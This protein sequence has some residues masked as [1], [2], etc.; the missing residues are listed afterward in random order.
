[1]VPDQPRDAV[2]RTRTAVLELIVSGVCATGPL[3][4]HTHLR[5]QTP[6]SIQSDHPLASWD[7]IELLGGVFFEGDP[8]QVAKSLSVR[9]VQ[10][11]GRCGGPVLGCSAQD[12]PSSRRVCGSQD[13]LSRLVAAV[14][15]VPES[16]RLQVPWERR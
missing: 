2:L 3:Q 13:K 4:Q 16:E 5:D 11:S 14:L 7:R 10:K 12:C 9:V 1:V 6:L 15:A 8:G